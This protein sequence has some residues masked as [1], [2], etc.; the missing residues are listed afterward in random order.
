MFMSQIEG[1]DEENEIICVQ[2]DASVKGVI[3]VWEEAPAA[4]GA[5]FGVARRANH[6]A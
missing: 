2:K 4:P 1:L 3:C 5:G 6:F